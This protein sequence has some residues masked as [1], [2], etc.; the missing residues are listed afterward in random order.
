[1]ACRPASELGST[2]NL[3]VTNTGTR[4]TPSTWRCRPC[5]LGR[6]AGQHV[7]HARSGPV[8]NRADRRGPID[9]A[10]PGGVNWWHRHVAGDSRR[11][12]QRSGYGRH[13]GR[14]GHDG[15][16]PTAGG[17]AALARSASFLL[18]VDNIGNIQDQYT[19]T[20]VGTSGLE[21]ASLQGL[22]GRSRQ[23][24][25]LF[26]LPGLSEG[27]ILVKADL[28]GAGPGLVTVQ[29]TSASDPTVTATAT[30]TVALTAANT[31]PAIESL[32]S[33]AAT[34]DDAV[35]AGQAVTISGTY[36]D[37]D[38]L[39]THSVLVDWGD[40][41]DPESLALQPGG[42]QPGTF[43]GSHAYA[44]GGIFTVSVTVNDSAGD[45]A[46]MTSEAY[47]VGVRLTDEGVLQIVGTT[48]R[49]F[50]DVEQIQHFGAGTIGSIWLAAHIPGAKHNDGRT[51]IQVTARFDQSSRFGRDD[52]GWG[53]DGTLTWAR[54]C[55]L[56]WET[57]GDRGQGY[58]PQIYS[59]DA[60]AVKSIEMVLCDG[61]DFGDVHAN[62][63]VA[64]RIDGGEGNDLL[65]GGSGNDVLLGG[66]G[67]DVLSGRVGNDLLDGGSGNDV[68]HGGRGNDILLGRQ[69]RDYLFGNRNRD[70][71]IGGDGRDVIYGGLADDILI[72]SSTQY[73]ENQAAL[74]A[75]LAEWTSNRPLS[76]RMANLSNGSGSTNRLNGSYFLDNGAVIDDLEA[77]VLVGVGGHNWLFQ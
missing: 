61:N 25:P 4:R 7:G 66:D 16:I 41:S 44:S 37:P 57:N 71:V 70:L 40:G 56:G 75:I 29:V 2:F 42:E 35:Q 36:S 64:A 14:A 63:S 26:I 59:F 77:D 52:F 65:L 20:I 23:S 67:Q 39:D 46:R 33:S 50:V 12:R 54:N 30:G 15:C 72:G 51:L 76:V 49:D 69:G 6:N 58:A 55:G 5:G 32:G 43:G 34:C 11:D 38:L 17:R 9:F 21:S 47:V 22:D 28:T 62:V 27:G 60:S 18:M 10:Y 13:A 24:V 73:D 53:G 1:M 68:L 74:M 48:G 31:A 19:A 45:T 8:A 3:T